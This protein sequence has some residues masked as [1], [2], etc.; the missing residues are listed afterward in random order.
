MPDIVALMQLHYTATVNK[1]IF[2]TLLSN[3]MPDIV[4]L[5]Q[6]H[7]TATVNKQ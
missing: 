1:G 3:L 5:M 7:Y 6:L 2:L 4:A